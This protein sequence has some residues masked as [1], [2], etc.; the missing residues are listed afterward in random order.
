MENHGRDTGFGRQYPE[1]IFVK[2]KTAPS[3]QAGTLLPPAG[4]VR[5]V[6]KN[7]GGEKGSKLARFDLIPTRALWLLAEVYGRGARKYADRNW[8]KGYA[9]GLSIAAL[10]RHFNAWKDGETIDEETG[11]H[12]LAQVAWHAFTLLTYQWYRLGTD[13]RSMVGKAKGTASEARW[14]HPEWA[15]A[16]PGPTQALVDVGVSVV[17]AYEQ[18][19]DKERY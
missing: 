9:W 2:A 10:E 4:E 7:T 17:T 8:E 6:D 12:H 13:D 16:L 5:L 18:T 11:C 1:D 15:P 3:A 14:K 19:R